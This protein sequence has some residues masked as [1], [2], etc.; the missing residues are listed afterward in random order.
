[1][2]THVLDS[3]ALAVRAKLHRYMKTPPG[4]MYDEC[5]MTKGTCG[6]I[7][8]Q[9]NKGLG[10]DED[11]YIVLG[12]LFSNV[13]GECL[14]SKRLTDEQ[15][16]ALYKWVDF[17]QDEDEGKWHAAEGFQQELMAVYSAAIRGL[18][19]ATPEAQREAGRDPQDLVDNIVE[20]GGKVTAKVP[21]SAELAPTFDS[22]PTVVPQ[23]LRNTRYG[24]QKE[25]MTKSKERRLLTELGYDS[26]DD[27]T[28]L[29]F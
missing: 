20:L 25:R 11:R 2:T 7:V 28:L 23:T 15:W 27:E 8:G 24:K 12:W 13:A 10:S 29:E 4:V 14:S 19:A 18:A 22:E 1:M 5:D 9:L 16:Y 17:W 3:Q 6:A 21:V 26:D